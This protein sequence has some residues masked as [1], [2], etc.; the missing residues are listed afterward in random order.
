MI[1][2][3]YQPSKSQLRVFGG[4]LIL[5][6]LIVGWQIL[7][8]FDA[9]VVA[10]AI[11]GILGVLGTIGLVA[12]NLLKPIYVGWTVA[13]FPIGWVVSHLL[14]AMIFYGIFTPIGLIRRT[15]GG[16]PL[17]RKLDPNAESYW[18]PTPEKPSRESYFR[19][20]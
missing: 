1:E 18:E 11:A 13:V 16:D 19:Q 2:I 5:F 15:V 6:A 7:R 20:S 10:Y 14:M 4:L 3:N 17:Q 8:H 12:P 9:K